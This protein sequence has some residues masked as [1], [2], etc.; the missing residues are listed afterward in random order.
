M[1][2]AGGGGGARTTRAGTGAPPAALRPSP[3][4]SRANAAEGRGSGAALVWP[5]PAGRGRLP[6]RRSPQGALPQARRLRHRWGRAAP[7][8]GV[9]WEQRSARR[10]RPLPS[11]PPLGGGGGAAGLP[12]SSSDGARPAAGTALLPSRQPLRGTR[13]GRRGLPAG[14]RQQAGR[15][16]R[17]T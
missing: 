12:R 17:R 10:A 13:R 3:R 11:S 1:L 16:G 5:T 15:G 6:P 9:G 4:R 2:P 14:R 7:S 8:G